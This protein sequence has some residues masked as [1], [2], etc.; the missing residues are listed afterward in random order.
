MSCGVWLGFLQS[1]KTIYE[2]AFARDLAMP[3]WTRTMNTAS[4]FAGRG[5]PQPETI[6]EAEVCRVS[7]QRSTPYCYEMFEDPETGIPRS[8]PAATGHSGSMPVDPADGVMDLS[9]L[10]VIDT[11]PVRPKEP[12]L[13]GNDPYHSI[14]ISTEN[15][16]KT[17]SR[18]GRI[19]VL[20]PFEIEEAGR[21]IELP[22]PKRL[23]ILPD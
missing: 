3:V 10:A 16:P 12:T 18:A 21:V 1:G 22:R 23:E 2:G 15:A 4:A 19:N 8:R 13:L 6:V 5:I 14:Q 11:S 9:E 7:G 20:D 17:R